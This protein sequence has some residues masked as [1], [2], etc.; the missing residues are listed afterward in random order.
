MTITP[1]E[2]RTIYKIIQAEYDNQIEELIKFVN[3]RSGYRNDNEL[4]LKNFLLLAQLFYSRKEIIHLYERYCKGKIETFED[5]LTKS[6]HINEFKNF[7][8][9]QQN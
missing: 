7:L 8:I 9:K 6:M 3:S 5:Y 1:D 4:S 2:I